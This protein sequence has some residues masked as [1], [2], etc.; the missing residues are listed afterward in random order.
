MTIEERVQHYASSYS[1]ILPK[2][3][4]ESSKE[5]WRKELEEV[6]SEAVATYQIEHEQKHIA[7]AV[8]VA[9]REERDKIIK[10]YG[11]FN[12]GCGCCMD[13]NLKKA[14]TPSQ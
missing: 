14:L 8:E 13:T 3:V 7:S 1:G 10:E 9:R 6:A 11:D 4:I 5:W 12:D 2:E